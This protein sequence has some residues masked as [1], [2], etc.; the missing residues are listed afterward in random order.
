MRVVKV[1]SSQGSLGKNDGCE[2]AP[3]LIFKRGEDVKIFKD[4]IEKTNENIYNFVKVNDFIIG[5]DHSIT[6]PCFKKFCKN[7]KNPGLLMFDAHPDCVNDFKPPSHEDFVRVLIE[8][9]FVKKENVILVG[10][11]NWSKLEKEFLDYNKIKCYYMDKIDNIELFCDGIMELCRIF[12]GVYLSIDIDVLDPAYA[13]GT[14][15]IE[16]GGLSSRELFYFLDRLKK[17]NNIKMV[18]LVEINPEKD[19][20]DMTLKIGKEIVKRLVDER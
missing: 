11:R 8:E 17:L 2:K 13:S 3:D 18:D 7:F 6:Y 10:L 5:G 16:P 4:N 15:Y 1:K 9:G 19:I 14:G 20:N 12:D